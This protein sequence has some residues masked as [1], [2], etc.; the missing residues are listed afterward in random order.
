MSW[1][2]NFNRMRCH[3]KPYSWPISSFANRCSVGAHQRDS[4][5]SV[6][7]SLLSSFLAVF[8]FSTEPQSLVHAT[9]RFPASLFQ[10]SSQF[11]YCSHYFAPRSGSAHCK[12][13]C[14]SFRK[15]KSSYLLK[16]VPLVSY[17]SSC[18]VYTRVRC[19]WRPVP[20]W[21]ASWTRRALSDEKQTCSP[22][23]PWPALTV[24]VPYWRHSQH[25]SLTHIKA[26]AMPGLFP[27]LDCIT[28]WREKNERNERKKGGG[29][30]KLPTSN[31]TPAALRP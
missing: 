26:S 27:W 2:L 21:V 30:K 1:S 19:H 9:S 28:P 29:K 14:I 15:C 16:Q 6:F 23:S 25:R 24:A 7:S 13:L 5:V 31:A 22:D 18:S 10:F 12:S 11:L 3:N 8:V 20:F 4:F 17:C